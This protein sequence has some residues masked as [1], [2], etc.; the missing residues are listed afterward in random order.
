MSII[1]FWNNGK[2]QTGKTLTIAAIATHMAIE[3][4][5]RTLV[6]STSYG[7][8]TLNKCFW[9]EIRTKKNRGLFGPNTN[10]GLEEGF[11][12][13]VKAMNS[14]RLSPES[15]KNYTK[16]IFKDR[17]E[18]LTS[19][20]TINNDYEEI[21]KSYIDIINIANQYYDLVLVDLDI[22]LGEEMVDKIL[23]N[24]SL[25]VATLSQRLSS[26]D[27]FIELRENKP[28]LKSLK[29]LILIGR[30]DKYSK[31]SVKNISRYMKEKNHVITVPYNTLF[32]EASEEAGVPDLF[33]R[34]RK[35]VDP[36]DRN[37]IFINE[38]KRAVDSIMYRLQDLSTK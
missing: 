18:I 29:T 17:L 9:K 24:S 15:V 1:T 21:K 30:Y 26:I 33:L 27:N 3:H 5:Y 8:T 19:P 23:S 34:L 16:T 2:E 14:N 13:L 37:A 10:I 28:I 25:I 22:G 7:D 36:E 6:I 31:Y 35:S 20:T 32:F 12:G 4:S 11:S 38:V